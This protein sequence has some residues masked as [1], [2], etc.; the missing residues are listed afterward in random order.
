M[1]H[2]S[3]APVWPALAVLLLV[4]GCST[5]R[6]EPLPHA[7]RVDIDRF[8]GDW[9]VIANIPTRP[10]RDAFNAVERYER[11]ADGTIATTFTFNQGSLDG[12]VKRMTPTGFVGK[13]A[14]QAIWG[15]RFVWPIKAEYVIS[16]VDADY[17]ETIVARSKRDYVWIMARSPHLP[18]ADYER[19]VEQVRDLGYN[20]SQLRRVPHR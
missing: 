2:S 3:R 11:N 20:T 7:P 13:D 15:M 6:H 17:R 12:P 9:Y 19:L 14:S 18:A 8:M 16:H 10:E 4:Q 1:N 5:M